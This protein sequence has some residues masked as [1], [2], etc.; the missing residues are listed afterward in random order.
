MLHQQ[1]QGGEGILLEEL[2]ELGLHCDPLTQ[3][4]VT[5]EVCRR[6]S[7]KQCWTCGMDICSFCTLK[8][9]WKV[10]EAP[11]YSAISKRSLWTGQMRAM[12][13]RIGWL[14]KTN[15]TGGLSA[16]LAID[17]FQPHGDTAGQARA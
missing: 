12:L 7:T 1:A 13:L 17:Q 9:H 4:V 15:V 16:A 3:L 2:E 6:P 11:S 10:N 14:M 8:R 5:C